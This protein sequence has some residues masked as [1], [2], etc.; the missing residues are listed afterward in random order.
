MFTARSYVDHT[1]LAQPNVPEQRQH[2]LLALQN[3][4]VIGLPSPILTVTVS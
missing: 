4:V 2:Q 1:P 3:D